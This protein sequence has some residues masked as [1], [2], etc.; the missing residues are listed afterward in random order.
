MHQGIADF[1][2]IVRRDVGRHSD[3]DTGRS[4]D[5]H[6]GQPGRE[7][8]W[9]VL[10]VVEVGD[11][12]DGVLVYVRQQLFGN[13]GQAGLRV[14]HRCRRVPVDAAE[15]ALAGDQ[16]VPQREFLR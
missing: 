8:H 5:Q 4:V 13:R 1:A 9:L 15:V 3:G 11:K 14:P 2:K 12:V 16:R 7:H 6:V 10:P